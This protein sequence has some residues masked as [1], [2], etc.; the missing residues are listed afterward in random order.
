MGIVAAIFLTIGFLS[1][2]IGLM[3][4]IFDALMGFFE[5]NF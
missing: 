2:P 5:Y 1:D 4:M 3:K